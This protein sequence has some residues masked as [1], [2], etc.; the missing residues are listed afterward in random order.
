MKVK[1]VESSKHKLLKITSHAWAMLSSTVPSIYLWFIDASST[2]TSTSSWSLAG[3]KEK[4]KLKVKVSYDSTDASKQ[5]LKMKVKHFPRL[6]W[7]YSLIP[8]V[9]VGHNNASRDVTR[10]SKWNVTRV[11]F[12]N[13]FTIYALTTK[14]LT[15]IRLIVISDVHIVLLCRP[16]DHDSESE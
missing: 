6:E 11:S 1:A 10:R 14:E 5:K 8:R 4:V 9:H 3:I 13:T 16:W 2:A 7:D 12:Q 15:S